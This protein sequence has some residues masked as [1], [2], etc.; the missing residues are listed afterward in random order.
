[1]NKNRIRWIYFVITCLAA[2]LIVSGESMLVRAESS[3]PTDMLQLAW[4]KAQEMG[5]YS[6]ISDINQTLIPRPVTVPFHHPARLITRCNRR[7]C[8]QA[9][10]RPC[11]PDSGHG[12]FP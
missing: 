4:Q 3:S 9:Q 10:R 8:S 5:S 6:F 7:S 2:L 12:S 11:S 1:M